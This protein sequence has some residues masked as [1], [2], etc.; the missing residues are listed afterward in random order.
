LSPD[1][2]TKICRDINDLMVNSEYLDKYDDKHK[3]ITRMQKELNML[4]HYTEID[5]TIS[6]NISEEDLQRRSELNSTISTVNAP[7]SQN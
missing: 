3:K 2:S 1:I 7:V 6:L 4:I 5:D